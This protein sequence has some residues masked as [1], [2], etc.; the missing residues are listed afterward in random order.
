[1]K[2]CTRC[3]KEHNS[4]TKFCELCKQY[5]RLR[6]TDPER[7]EYN[8]QRNADPKVREMKHR[9]DT[10]PD[11]REKRRKFYHTPEGRSQARAREL[12]RK[13]GLTLEDYDSMFA[14]QN[15]LCAICENPPRGKR[16]GGRTAGL[17]VDHHHK[18]NKVRQLLCHWCNCALGNANES[19][20]RLRKMA[21]YLEY[22]N[23][24]DNGHQL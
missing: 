20:E 4:A 13:Y 1:M 12:I 2:T 21:D 10:D 17:F 19:P 9:Y 7:R 14:S 3:K 23:Q 8:R 18:T 22:H 6:N 24:L 5:H 15:G 16:A 11:V